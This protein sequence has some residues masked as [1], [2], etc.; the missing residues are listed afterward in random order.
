MAKAAKRAPV[1]ARALV[2]RINRKLAGED[3]PKPWDHGPYQLVALRGAAAEEF[4][5]WV[6]VPTPNLADIAGHG[7]A[8][9][10]SRIEKDNVDLEGFGRELGVLRP[11]EALDR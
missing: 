5:K 4:G 6:I 11:W 1:T 7:S 3:A 2:Q 8:G 9:P 10:L